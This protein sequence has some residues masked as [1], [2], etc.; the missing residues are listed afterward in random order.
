M[1]YISISFQHASDSTA[2]TS[3][4]GDV[5]SAAQ[6]DSEA[7]AVT[8]EY[9]DDAYL[10]VTQKRWEDDVVWAGEDSRASVLQCMYINRAC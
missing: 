4:S 9:P 8:V 5:T 3:V 2:S 6:G 1:S 7:A 10:M